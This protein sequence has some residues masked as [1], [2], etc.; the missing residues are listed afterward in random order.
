M[1][2]LDIKNSEELITHIII[3]LIW[4]ICLIILQFMF[5]LWFKLHFTCHCRFLILSFFSFYPFQRLDSFTIITAFCKFIYLLIYSSRIYRVTSPIWSM[6]VPASEANK[7]KHRHRRGAVMWWRSSEHIGRWMS[8]WWPD[9]KQVT[10]RGSSIIEK[11]LFDGRRLATS[12]R[13]ENGAK[14]RHHAAIPPPT[15]VHGLW[16]DDRATVRGSVASERCDC[17][18]K[19]YILKKLFY[20]P[21]DSSDTLGEVFVFDRLCFLRWL[22]PLQQYRK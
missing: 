17:G 20:L 19:I 13:R 1:F 11:W 12:H 6:R 4:F 16:I 22:L 21:G 9:S 7:N 8:W 2:N 15:E 18:F 5:C 3:L 14:S 10:N